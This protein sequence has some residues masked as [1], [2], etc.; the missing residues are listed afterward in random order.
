MPMPRKE[1]IGRLKA[2]LKYAVFATVTPSQD[3]HGEYFCCS[4]TSD[5]YWPSCADPDKA[6]IMLTTPPSSAHE[7]QSYGKR[8][9]GSSAF[10]VIAIDHDFCS[11]SPLPPLHSLTWRHLEKSNF[12][13]MVS[14]SP[15][16][17]ANS[18]LS[19]HP[20]ASV[21]EPCS[22]EPS[23]QGSSA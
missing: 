19:S 1:R 15:A 18:R 21:N 2:E 13:A 20:C 10:T 12:D 9:V 6:E 7:L 11:F 8:C 16:L 22:S 5:L 17:S 23:P 14:A 4:S 3:P